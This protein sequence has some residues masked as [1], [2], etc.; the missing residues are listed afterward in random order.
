MK[1]KF[2]KP[3]SYAWEEAQRERNYSMSK[4]MEIVARQKGLPV[5]KE[6][7]ISEHEK[8]GL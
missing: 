2:R 6:V 5:I 1:Q 8:R 4:L 7:Y 3:Y